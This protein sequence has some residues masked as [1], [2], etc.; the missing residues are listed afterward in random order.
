MPEDVDP[1][2]GTLRVGHVFGVTLTKWRGRWDARFPETP[3]EVVEVD[4]A[5]QRRALDE[6][7]VDACFVR[8]PLDTDGLHVV[9][10]YDELT[11]AWASKDHG[12]TLYDSLTLADLEGEATYTEVT[13][14]TLLEVEFGDGVLV[15]PMSVARSHGRRDFVVRE[16]SDA[17]TTAIALAWPVA[18]DGETMQE[19]VGIVRGRTVNSSRSAKA[20]EA[21]RPSRPRPQKA[22]TRTNARRPSPGAARSRRRGQSR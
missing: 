6:G 18:K 16:I 9:P 2:E 1:I 7:R 12:I 21:K 17:P 22:P 20:E 13:D 3:L 15:L 14:A 19:F 8:L 10:L 11:V 4:R 5:D